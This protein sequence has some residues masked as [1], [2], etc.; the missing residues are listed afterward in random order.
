MFFQGE[1]L[2]FHHSSIFIKDNMNDN[3]DQN[4]AP[5]EVK[6]QYGP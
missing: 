5:N 3:L 4:K 1:I 2:V 6:S